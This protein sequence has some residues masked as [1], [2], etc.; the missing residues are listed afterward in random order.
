M[1]HVPMTY[2]SRRPLSQVEFYKHQCRPV[3]KSPC[4]KSNLKNGPV[5]LSFLR[6]KGHIGDLYFCLGYN[7]NLTD[8]V[9]PHSPPPT[10]SHK[11]CLHIKLWGSSVNISCTYGC[12]S[13]F[14]TYIFLNGLLSS[15]CN[16][17]SATGPTELLHAK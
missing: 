16:L 13:L 3:T 14:F 15:I 2:V 12:F 8:S 6:F 10:C 5:T 1:S 9:N 17:L 7:Y 11:L 4:R